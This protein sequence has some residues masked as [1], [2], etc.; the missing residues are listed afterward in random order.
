MPKLSYAA[1]ASYEIAGAPLSEAREIWLVCHGYGQLARH[2]IRR[3]DVLPADCAVVAAQGL[4]RFYL[5]HHTGTYKQVGASWLTRDER[6]MDLANM[7][8]YLSAL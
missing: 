5:D 1:T 7:L 4:S 2:F 8:A 6:E 3:F